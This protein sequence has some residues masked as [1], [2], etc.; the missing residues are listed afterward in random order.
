[1]LGIDKE[2]VLRNLDSISERCMQVAPVLNKKGEQI[3]VETPD[4]SMAPAFTF[5]SSG[6]I[7]ANELVGKELGM[8]KQQVEHEA[9]DGLAGLLAAVREE[10]N[11]RQSPLPSGE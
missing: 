11:S 4:G 7:R 6:A 1:R 2:K 8:F 10:N 5:D 9:G 3:W